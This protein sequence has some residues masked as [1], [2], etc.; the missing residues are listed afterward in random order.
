[1]YNDAMASEVESTSVAGVSSE[2]DRFAPENRELAAGMSLGKYRLDHVLGRGGMGVVWAAHDPD[3]DR[4]VALKV[5][6]YEKPTLALRRRL[7]REARAMARLKHP[8][9]CTVY[10]VDSEGDRD[11]IAMELVEGT[12]LDRWLATR[13]SRNEIWQVIV[14]AGRGLAA[15]HRAG[16]V[17]RDFKPQ[18]VLRSHDGRVL[19]TDFGLARTYGGDPAA[20]LATDDATACD[21]KS[22]LDSS[23]THSGALLGT[24]T[25]M[26]PEQFLGACDPRTDQFAYCVTAWRLLSGEPPF[27]GATIEEL[28]R[29]VNDGPANAKGKLP[30]AIR[31]VLARGLDPDREKRWPN[32]DALLAALERAESRSRRRGQIGAGVVAIGIVAVLGARSVHEPSSAVASVICETNPHAEM[33]HAWFPALRAHLTQHFAG[34]A[35][36][37]YLTGELDRF[38]ARWIDDYGRA[39]A[40]PRSTRTFAKLACLLGARDELSGFVELLQSLSPST[41]AEIDMGIMLPNVQAC[42][43]ESPLAS[44]TL[45]GDPVK[46]DKIRQL[47]L[48]ILRAQ[49]APPEQML[50]EMPGLVA[51]A[52]ALGW[53]PII[54]EAHEGFAITARR[55]GRRSELERDHYRRA[56][57]IAQRSH[58]YRLEAKVSIARLFSELDAASEP[59]D[60]DAFAHLLEHARAAVH[61]GGDDPVHVAY[62]EWAEG[63]GLKP[64][65]QLDERV[66][67]YGAA[68]TLALSARDFQLAVWIAC[69]MALVLATRN[70]AGDL[71][72]A[73]EMLV[74]TERAATAAR[75]PDDKLYVLKQRFRIVALLRG[76]LAA[77]HEWSD[78][79]GAATP[80]NGAVAMRG[81][82]VDVHGNAVGGATVVAWV[83]ILEGDARRAYWRAPHTMDPLHYEG[84]APPAYQ[85]PGFDADVATTDAEGRFTVRAAPDGG[86]IAELGDRRSRPRVI[87]NGSIVLR[88]EPTRTI[89]GTVAS[90]HEVLSGIAITARYQL[91]RTLAWDCTAAVG[92]LHDYHLAGLPGGR[93]T[94]RLDD[95]SVRPRKLEFGPVRDGAELRWPAG[96]ALD[97]I[98]RG[99]SQ[100]TP[101][102]YLLR[103]HETARTTADLDRLVDRAAAATVNPALVVGAGDLSVEGMKYYQR[104]DRH[105]MLFDTAPGQVTVCVAEADP[106]SAAICQTIEVPETTPKIRDGHDPVIPVIFQR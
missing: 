102:V 78:R 43:G 34:S 32:M 87:G 72:A 81:R 98:V 23:L 83:G 77:V 41:L 5:V 27:R 18:N 101:W 21:G 15:A 54:A 73:W 19:V 35:D 97:V 4:A 85:R 38:A 7:L 99:G 62:L 33:E 20:P 30:A 56:S 92:R 3:L 51:E 63:S 95:W 75:V 14:A 67:K 47:R 59:A 94:L 103:G 55:V 39:C 68:R 9:V 36:V 2:S 29:A 90:D 86:I 46:R 24:P 76:D 69:D 25:Y 13:P 8:N 91:G 106:T 53:D 26:A 60:P 66:A 40:S 42:D 22:V 28:R 6:R 50:A 52:E 1:M 12:H 37:G 71:D 74:D 89:E 44:P 45:P 58:H 88:L 79:E 31:A 100:R 93:A 11:F 49:F 70:R 48:R 61:D 16:L 80:A 82:V 105:R 65:G 57:E 84:D 64:S 10:E 96:P 17:H 104:N